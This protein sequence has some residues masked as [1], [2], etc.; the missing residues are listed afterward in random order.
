MA[1]AAQVGKH[2]AKRESY[3]HACII[4]PWVTTQMLDLD[5]SI[6]SS[7]MCGVQGEVVASCGEKDLGIAV[8]QVD[9]SYM[10]QIRTNMPVMNH[11]RPD[12]YGAIATQP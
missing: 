10:E 2:N 3:G 4:D 9:L 8:A 12:V 11:R 7:S 5:L 1:A 6:F